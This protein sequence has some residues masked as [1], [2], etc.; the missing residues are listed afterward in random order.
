MAEFGYS[1]KS[2]MTMYIMKTITLQFAQHYMILDM[3][4]FIKFTNT[5]VCIYIKS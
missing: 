5:T 1:N 4:T 2:L 3:N